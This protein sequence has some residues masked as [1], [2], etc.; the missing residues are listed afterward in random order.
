[1]GEKLD[2][3]ELKKQLRYQYNSGNY[4]STIDLANIILEQD[5]EYY[6]AIE[7][8]VT[9]TFNII[10]SAPEG[11][12]EELSEIYKEQALVLIKYLEKKGDLARN[13]NQKYQYLVAQNN[14]GW[15]A[16]LYSKKKEEW[17]DGLKHVEKGLKREVRTF[18]LDTKLRLLLK[19]GKK[20]KGYEIALSMLKKN[21]N[22]GD[23]QDIKHNED[24]MEWV[25]K[26][27]PSDVTIVDRYAGLNSDDNRCLS[28]LQAITRRS[29]P[30]ITPDQ[31]SRNGFV[32]ENGY[33]TKLC[34]YYLTNAES[35]P[36]SLGSLKSLKELEITYCY[37]LKSL[38]ESLVNLINLEILTISNCYDLE[39]LPDNIDKL[40][41]LKSLSLRN[42][43]NIQTLP[44]KLGELKN[45]ETLKIERCNINSFPES[46][47]N[48]KKLAIL[49]LRYCGNLENLPDTIGNLS[50]LSKLSILDLSSLEMLPNGLSN[51]NSLEE[52]VLTRINKLE[53]LPDSISGLINLKKLDIQ[54]NSN[55][56]GLPETIGNLSSLE[57]FTLRSCS[58]LKKIP[59][60]FGNLRNLKELLISQCQGLE[61]FSIEL[62]NLVNLEI[63]K[64]ESLSKDLKN[65]PES[66]GNLNKLRELTID[67][68]NGLISIPK[69]IGNLRSLVK[70]M[71]TDCKAL[72]ALPDE[73]ANISSLEELII[74]DCTNLEHLSRDITKLD[75][76]QKLIIQNCPNLELIPD[77]FINFK[78][79]KEIVITK[80]GLK[81]KPEKLSSF[82]KLEHLTLSKNI[83]S[84]GREEKLDL[85]GK[86]WGKEHK[87][88]RR[89][90]F[91][92]WDDN[93]NPSFVI[94]YGKHEYMGLEISISRQDIE[95][96]A[97][98]SK[99][100]GLGNYNPDFKEGI[101]KVLQDDVIYT[102]YALFRGKKGHFPSYQAVKI[103]EQSHY[104]YKTRTYSYDDPEMYY[105]KGIEYHWS[106]DLRNAEKFDEFYLLKDAEMLSLPYFTSQ[107]YEER[108]KKIKEQGFEVKGFRFANSLGEIL[109][110]PE[111][112]AEYANI[113]IDMMSQPNIYMRKKFLAEF[114]AK[115]PP[116]SVLNALLTM[117][118]SEVV[119]GL[120]LEL[121]KT[122][123]PIILEQA[124]KL[125]ESDITWV[126][127]N[128][129]RGIKRCAKLYI[130]SLD[131]DVKSSR[132]EWIRD[133]L[134]NM[135]LHL[136]KFRGEIIPLDKIIVGSTYR[137]YAMWGYLRDSY[138]Y[139]NYEKHERIK[140]SNRYEVGAYTDGMQFN[141]I[142][143][144]N[145][146]QESEIYGLADVIGKIAY[147]IDAPRLAYYLKGN[148]ST[149]ALK[150]FQGYLRRIINSY[151]IKNEE[152]FIEAM[153]TMLTSYK[154]EDCLSKYGNDYE[155]N[156]FI[157]YYLYKDYSE[158]E[159][160]RNTTNWEERSEFYS[161]PK[162]MRLQGRREYKKEI[163]DRHLDAAA[164][165]A[166]NSQVMPIVKA[167]YFILKD[168]PELQK[169][170]EN[171]KYEL[172]IQLSLT[173]YE[174]L[175]EL[176]SNVLNEKMEKSDTFDPELM[177]A[178]IGCNSERMH[179]YGWNYFK[180]TNG[181]F[182]PQVVADFL[183][184][185]NL[186]QWTGLFQQ[187]IAALRGDS[188]G[189]FLKHLINKSKE[190]QKK[191][192]LISETIRDILSNSTG[193]MQYLSSANKAELF[194]IV[195]EMIF[196]ESAILDWIMTFFEEVI[197][198]LSQEDLDNL[199]KDVN[200][201]ASEKIISTKR[202]MILAI[203]QSIKQKT[204]P[205]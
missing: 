61:S 192:V 177:L 159:P 90:V 149:K 73:L 125:I 156:V 65:L 83:Y 26:K 35:L 100:S 183:L 34:I 115:N 33:I 188:Y 191:E 52:L 77:D 104:D 185:Q 86:K 102:C 106:W 32:E 124:R 108:L 17:K 85:I 27:H 49:E 182:S 30:R 190:L 42:A 175:S 145:T 168:S 155:Y 121:A 80:S 113:I 66:I 142:E 151:A 120:F 166:L 105:K 148:R 147:Y 62:D 19:L 98:K 68:C 111:T 4:T 56:S 203:L 128:Y 152:K 84:P 136:I 135:D 173:S 197:F 64:I 137:K 50:S 14:I 57:L 2:L 43:N 22:E 76:L 46:I 154:P 20:D 117:V 9:A 110:I 71:F 11:Q 44:H 200:L 199:L 144:K 165:I 69:T 10:N 31:G 204:L 28:D 39:A 40:I 97:E 178:L 193:E 55:L 198:S 58:K 132:T 1:M 141:L 72:E 59:V 202:R 187:S 91:W 118:S 140:E 161:T 184:L 170:I 38:P 116:E 129:A 157:K 176:F 133:T 7:L 131:P 112:H 127:S 5:P 114:L 23:V 180:R 164:E 122:A 41:N 130:N 139:Y 25:K 146:I 3:D 194:N 205:N 138:R 171:M 45:L 134:S 181:S 201:E 79:I 103:I 150:Y 169:F 158:V 63:F 174:P 67:R 162:F 6:D 99:A 47:G 51:L 196:K 75:S 13:S 74:K 92:G 167:C 36:E 186:D 37:R 189:S 88:W 123:N 81:T 93:N 15:N 48:L 109:Q 54:N 8:R 160:D 24:F 12:K 172:L 96:Y 107:S 179:E 163:W 21:E 126:A 153:K 195:L 18:A 82:K 60:S 70:L 94:I 89:M 95:R 53:S 16:Y 143:F 78:S 119:S 29:I 101:Y 87:P